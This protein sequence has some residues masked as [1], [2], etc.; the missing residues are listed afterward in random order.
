MATE[1][2]MRLVA[3]PVQAMWPQVALRLTENQQL[4]CQE[5]TLCL[6]KSLVL[7]SSK[8]QTH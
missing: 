2:L 1:A 7:P 4:H 5:L 6:Q 8:A 3:S